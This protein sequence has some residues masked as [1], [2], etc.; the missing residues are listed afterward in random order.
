VCDLEIKIPEGKVCF[1]N[2]KIR[3]VKSNCF[4]NLFDEK[5]QFFSLCPSLFSQFEC[6][7]FLCVYVCVWASYFMSVRLNKR[8]N[9]VKYSFFSSPLYSISIWPAYSCSPARLPSWLSVGDLPK[10]YPFKYRVLINIFL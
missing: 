2:I 6:A 9:F 4:F 7:L 10:K 8:T 5:A 3:D 1:W